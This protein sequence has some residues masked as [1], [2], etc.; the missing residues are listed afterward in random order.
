MDPHAN[1]SGHRIIAQQL[2]K[3]FEELGLLN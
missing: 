1:A 2:L 3:G